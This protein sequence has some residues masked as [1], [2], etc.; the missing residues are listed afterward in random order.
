MTM[1]MGNMF[2]SLP[3][4]CFFGQKLI[5]NIQILKIFSK[6]LHISS[7]EIWFRRIFEPICVETWQLYWHFKTNMVR[8]ITKSCYSLGFCETKFIC[9]Q[10]WDGALY[11]FT[12]YLKVLWHQFSGFPIDLIILI[13]YYILIIL[14]PNLRLVVF[15]K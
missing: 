2:L 10:V 12:C 5:I 11:I 7:P 1:N 8:G 14:P 3:K 4:N 15:A 6:K 9:L 13:I